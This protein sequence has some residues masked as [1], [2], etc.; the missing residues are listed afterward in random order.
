[1]GHISE[2]VLVDSGFTFTL[3]S[4][5]VKNVEID[6]TLCSCGTEH[7]DDCLLGCCTQ[8]V[9]AVSNV[10]MSVNFYK[11]MWRKIPDDSYLQGRESH[12]DN[13]TLST[14]HVINCVASSFDLLGM[15]FWV[16][17]QS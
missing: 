5:A 3:V 17:H 7:E 4:C 1:V 15:D 2:V 6:E 14:F 8:V 12:V 11:T 16:C 9:E 13:T 10:E